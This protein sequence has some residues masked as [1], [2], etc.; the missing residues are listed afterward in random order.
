MLAERKNCH[1]IS[2]GVMIRNLINSPDADQ[3]EMIKSI[4]QITERG[5]LIDDSLIVTLLKEEMK[6]HPYANG[7]LI[8]GCPRTQAQLDIFE[9]DIDKCD[10]VLYLHLGKE[11]MHQ[12][13][14]ERAAI[15]HRTDDNE[16]AMVNRLNIFQKQ[17]LPVIEYLQK[18][19]DSTFMQVDTSEDKEVV[20]EK[21][22]KQFETVGV[23]RKLDVSSDDVPPPLRPRF[24]YD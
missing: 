4:K 12:R 16:F 18:N 21:I 20:A 6:K 17:T 9:R 24:V 1:H 8:D 3:S 5:N 23:K 2:T 19:Y 10:K 15:E 11:A 7:F 13:M 14:I 22:A